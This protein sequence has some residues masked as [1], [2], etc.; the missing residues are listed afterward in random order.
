ML[1]G[2]QHSCCKV[3]ESTRTNFMQCLLYG[4]CT[5]LTLGTRVGFILPAPRPLSSSAPAARSLCAAAGHSLS[6]P[7]PV[8][9]PGGDIQQRSGS[10]SVTPLTPG[11][12]GS[13]RSGFPKLWKH[14]VTTHPPTTV[15]RALQVLSVSCRQ[16]LLRH[17]NAHAL[18]LAGSKRHPI[19]CT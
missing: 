4:S 5:H 16:I 3:P 1:E 14:E 18:I 7:C 17:H 11:W 13:H 2:S 10:R 9:G 8:A 15:D 6:L 19:Y 12:A